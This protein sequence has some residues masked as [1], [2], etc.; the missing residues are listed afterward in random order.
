MPPSKAPGAVATGPVGRCVANYLLK[1]NKGVRILAPESET[2]AWPEEVEIVQGTITNPAEASHAFQDIEQVFLAGFVGMIPETLREFT[3]L[4]IKG[5]A[6]R[7]LVLSS[8]GA[9]FESEYFLETWHWL[10]FERAVEKNDAEWTYIR[11]TAVMANALVGGYPI[12]GA[13]WC[14]SI[15]AGRVVQEFLPQ[16]P[17]PFID[18]NDLAGVITAVLLKGGYHGKILEVS[19][20]MIS[21]EERL[22]VIS[23]GCTREGATT[24][25]AYFHMSARKLWKSLGWPDDTIEVTLWASQE[26]AANRDVTKKHIAE[27]ENTTKHILG[28]SP[29]TFSQWVSDHIEE[30]S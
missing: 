24:R 9:E 12:T 29:R 16:A 5:G 7:F 8:H 18:E 22:R 15:K 14:E 4:A 20:E 17:Y 21:A 6:R 2:T 28:R 27:Y 10:A 13:S 26:F 11:P 25:R 30:F 19:G 3:N 23:D 1:S